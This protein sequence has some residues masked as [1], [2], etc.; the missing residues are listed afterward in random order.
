M[1]PLIQVRST[2]LP[3]VQLIA[4]LPRFGTVLPIYEM[5]ILVDNL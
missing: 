5:V 2:L 1:T 3:G 4:L